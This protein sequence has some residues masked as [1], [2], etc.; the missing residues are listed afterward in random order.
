MIG[1]HTLQDE[2]FKDTAATI[3]LYIRISYLGRSV[4]T[5]I[6]PIENTLG[7]FCAHG[8]PDEE[9]PYHL[10]QLTVKQL[11]SGHWDGGLPRIPRARL[12]CRCEEL[13]GKETAYPAG[14]QLMIQYMAGY[15]GNLEIQALLQNFFILENKATFNFNP[16]MKLRLARA[17]E[18]IKPQNPMHSPQTVRTEFFHTR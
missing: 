15:S 11:Q 16:D 14:N 2:N 13:V 7:S 1:I 17:R 18:Q 4:I 12:I 3:S 5:E 8:K 9:Q 10:Q 6:A